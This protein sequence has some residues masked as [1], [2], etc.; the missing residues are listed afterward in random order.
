M[1]REFLLADGQYITIDEIEPITRERRGACVDRR[2]KKMFD[3]PMTKAKKYLITNFEQQ[4][5][6]SALDRANGNV[7]E[8]ARLAGKERRSFTRLLEKY[9]LGRAP[10]NPR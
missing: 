4:Y 9:D 7:S 5:L 1:H 10:H 3:Q 2:L 6:S 8:A